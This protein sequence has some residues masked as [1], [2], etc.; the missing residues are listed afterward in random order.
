MPGNKETLF[1]KRIDNKK[2]YMIIN[3]FL[4]DG[5]TAFKRMLQMKEL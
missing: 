2:R 5:K 1:F 4:F 3:Y